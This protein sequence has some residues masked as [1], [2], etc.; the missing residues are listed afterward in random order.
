MTGVVLTRFLADA[1][2]TEIDAAQPQPAMGMRMNPG[3]SVDTDPKIQK[4][5][6][7]TFLLDPLSLEDK[8]KTSL[9]VNVTITAKKMESR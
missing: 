3:F 8:M 5:T 4:L 7:F 6:V 2:P 9:W 1:K